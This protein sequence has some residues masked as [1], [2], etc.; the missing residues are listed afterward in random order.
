MPYKPKER[1]CEQCNNTYLGIPGRKYCGYKCSKKALENKKELNCSNCN[2]PFKVQNYRD[3][4]YCSIKCKNEYN[5][6]PI[7]EKQCKNCGKLFNRKS[8]R[9][10]SDN[11]FCSRSCILIF[12]R[13][14]NHYE[15]KEHLHDKHL[16]LALK[17]WGKIIKKR[18]NYICQKCGCDD[19]N[20][21]EAHHIKSQNL[22]PDLKFNFDN[23][24]TLC[25]RCHALA[26]EGDEKSLRL[27]NNKIKRYYNIIWQI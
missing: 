4:K 13:G 27:I 9:V 20:C 15:Y 17:Q 6:S 22:F 24:I 8:H 11:S 10:K 5:S 26:H 16:K 7:I 23:G 21:M 12:N 3:A 19:K 25:L 18:D 2:K 14:S 1:I